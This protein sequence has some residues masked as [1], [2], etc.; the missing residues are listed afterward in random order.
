[1]EI[2]DMYVWEAD[3]GVE[4]V[5]VKIIKGN[6][7]LTE[8]RIG[9]YGK[10]IYIGSNVGLV[11]IDENEI[12]VLAHEDK[13]AY[14][15]FAENVPN[16]EI[17]DND[18]RYRGA[19]KGIGINN[20]VYLYNATSAKI[21]DNEFELE[22]VS[23]EVPWKEI[24]AG[25]YNWVSF[26]VSEG[27]VV[28]NSNGVV[29]DNNYVAVYYNNISGSY[30][31]IYSVSFKNSDD[32]LITNNDINSYGFS[33][34]YGIYMSGEDFIIRSN[35]I[36]SFSNYYA[37][38][39][40]IEGPAS[41][42]VE[43]NY[44]EV[45]ADNSV[46][47][48]YSGMNGQ[49]VSVE[50]YKNEIYGYSYNV[51]GF[52]LGDVE[53]DIVDNTI[54]LE[55][56]YTTG[57]AFKGKTINIEDNSIKL[58]SDEIGDMY[59]WEANFGVETV[60]IKLIEG[61]ATVIGNII[62]TSGKGI[63]V[64]DVN[65]ADIGDNF[66]EVVA[67]VDKDAYAIYAEDV[68]GLLVY[69]NYITYTGATAGNGINNAVYLYNATSA[70]I[71][72]NEFDL[73]LVSCEVPWKEIPAGSGNWVSFSVSEGIVVVDSDDVTF[74]K[75][76]VDVE[77]NEVY[78]AFDTI[79]TVD[80]ITS[81][82]AVIS[83][84]NITANGHSYVYGIIITSD[85]F[86]ICDNRILVLSDN[87]YANGI[88]PDADASG[89]VENNTIVA[90]G[91]EFSYPIY[92]NMYG[93]VTNFNVDYIGNEIYGYARNV[94]GLDLNGGIENI[95]N[96]T[97]I[98]EGGYTCAIKAGSLNNTISDNIIRSL[99]TSSEDNTAITV[100]KGVA[101]ISD[102][103][104]ESIA[105]EYAIDL[106]NTN[107]TVDDNYITGRKNEGRNAIANPGAGAIIKNVSPGYKTILFALDAHYVYKDGSVY[108]VYALDENGK[109]ISGITI[110][111]A[112]GFVNLN[113]TTDA[114]GLARFTSDLDAGDHNITFTFNGNDDY[115]QATATG[116]IKVDLRSTQIVVPASTTVL[117]TA[118]KS[119]TS[120]ITLTLKDSKGN[121]LANRY[122]NIVFNGKK[123][124][125]VTDKN[126]AIKY[127]L[128]T[129]KEGTQTLTMSFDGDKNYLASSATTKVKFTKEASK[130]TAKKKS[131]KAKKKTKKYTVTLKDSKNKGINKAKISLK[132]KGQYYDAKTNS[133]GKAVFKIKKLSK[134][135]KYKAKVKYEGNNYYNAASKSVKITVK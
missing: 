88:N 125:Y 63:Y 100:S 85:N 67:N 61:D 123:G 30:D 104:I 131:F 128:D 90:V 106:G 78:G 6:A 135:G 22:L 70:I 24:P 62:S 119:Q 41:G 42:V 39:I 33:Y 5:G 98:A 9:S 13:D 112:Y 115:A 116:H 37:N 69:Q 111:A 134:K 129:S 132:I 83:E 102:N 20:A 49:N 29:F 46:Y 68:P 110:V 118:V 82:N 31:T 107:S 124:V 38:G 81:S 55:G 21:Y 8:N 25:S 91:K 120:F 45:E 19:T 64:A 101:N 76:V 14:A 109:P 3:F 52:S 43:S 16:L 127:L 58:A 96:N 66:I 36:S 18:I 7:T 53:S 50:Y 117:L 47:A 133:K 60:G 126:G 34:I 75:N 99:G 121:L 71:V 27:I 94:V 48:I 65:S 17:H 11:D 23:C 84:N 89:I 93:D 59:V 74:Y 86:T 12:A 95:I 35:D 108:S 79:Y 97:I 1:S 72:D 56:N 105:G 32:A 77:Y 114:N 87:N 80:F 40:D 92:S 4:S 51:F 10:A 113:A 73:E 2:G 26:P 57:I 130:L 15:I 54:L 122:V 28:E 103:Y 44:I